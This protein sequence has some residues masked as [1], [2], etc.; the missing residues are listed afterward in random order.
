V[1]LPLCSI[2]L[3]ATEGGGPGAAANCSCAK[4]SW[5]AVAMDAAPS[6]SDWSSESGPRSLVTLQGS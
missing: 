5:L 6:S 1:S 2:A 4:P 3:P